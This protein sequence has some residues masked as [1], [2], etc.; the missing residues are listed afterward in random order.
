MSK[1]PKTKMAI[2]EALPL[3]RSDIPRT[4][5]RSLKRGTSSIVT[6]NSQLSEHLPAK[7]EVVEVAKAI[8]AEEKVLAEDK[9]ED[10]ESHEIKK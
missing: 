7:E 5:P 3:S 8:E 6:M 2:T 4:A 9:E 1:F 10:G